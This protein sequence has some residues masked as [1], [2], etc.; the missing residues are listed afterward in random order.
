MTSDDDADEWDVGD[1]DVSDDF[2]TAENLF[3]RF[4]LCSRA[5]R[6]RPGARFGCA[7]G[8]EGSCR[9]EEEL[10]MGDKGGEDTRGTEGARVSVGGGEA[11]DV[12]GTVDAMGSEGTGVD[13]GVPKT[14]PP[15]LPRA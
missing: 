4:L 15:A 1:V 9:V 14:L 7:G 6:L 10:A 13:E 2:L 11:V 3:S 5:S 12:T 8:D